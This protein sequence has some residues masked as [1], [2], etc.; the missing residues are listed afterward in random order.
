MRVLVTGG[1]G[2]IGSHTVVALI[3]AGHVVTVVDNLANSSLSVLDGIAAITGTR[4]EFHQ[5]DVG[6]VAAMEPVVAQGEFEAVLHFAAFKAVG[7]SVAHPLRYYD[8]NVAGTVRLLEVL[9]DHSVRKLVFSSS[10][11]VYGDPASLPLTEESPTGRA[12][13]P[14]G[15]SKIMMEQVLTDVAVAD[16]SWSMMLLRYFN[17]VG[18]HPSGLIGELPAGEPANLLPYVAGVAARRFPFVRIFGTDYP[19]ADGTAVR[20]YVHVVDVAEGHVAAL[21]TAVAGRHVYNL[22]TGRG[23]SVLEVIRTFA[24]ATG[25][26]VPWEAYPRRRGDV[27]ATWAGVEKAATNLGWTPRFELT[28]M[29]VDA[30]RWQQAQGSAGSEQ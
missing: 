6:D 7:E 24:E 15:W 20:D 8:N 19:T 23:S 30:W 29:C 17:P 5:V 2:F 21:Q 14:Y 22:G 26:E 28:D 1:T 27:A 25:I 4:P 3:E 18:A 11:T 9:S 13:N 12:T 16:P 10:A